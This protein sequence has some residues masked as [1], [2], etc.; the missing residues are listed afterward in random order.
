MCQAVYFVLYLSFIISHF[1]RGPMG[2]AAEMG[3]VE[4]K[5]SHPSVTE[6]QLGLELDGS[7][8]QVPLLFPCSLL[9]ARQE[10]NLQSSDSIRFFNTVTF[11]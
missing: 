7:S 1:K 2:P 9:C 11:A 4:L 3:R 6:P 10:L 5:R 8:F